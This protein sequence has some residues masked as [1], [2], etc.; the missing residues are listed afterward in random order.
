M[1]KFAYFLLFL[2]LQ[3]II[4]TAVVA[5]T[6]TATKDTDDGFIVVHP[7]RSYFK[8]ELLEDSDVESDYTL[9]LPID[10]LGDP[11]ILP[12]SFS[13]NDVGGK[14][15]LTKL[16]NQH[17]PQYC[18]SCWAHS[19]LSALADRIKIARNGTGIDINLRI[20]SSPL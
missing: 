14:S 2:L 18:G 4:G 15:Y 1:T 6:A 17:I 20:V 11:E 8:S 19:A 3:S 13:W 7:R 12:E 5:T 10:Y 9:P 16:L